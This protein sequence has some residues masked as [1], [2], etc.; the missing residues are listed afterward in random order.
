MKT[1]LLGMLL[2]ATLAALLSG[3]GQHK[4]PSEALR[5]VRVAE[6]RYDASQETNRYFGSVQARYEVDQ[7]F[8]VGGKV[9]TRKVDVGQKVRRGD[10]LATLDDTDYKLAVE[11][12]QQQLD[13]A[14]TQA[15]QAESDR[16][17]LQ[18]LKVDGSVSVSDDERATSNAATTKANAEAPHVAVAGGH[19]AGQVFGTI[20]ISATG[21]GW[22]PLAR[23]PPL[24]S[25]R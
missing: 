16:Q 21:R 22:T 15:R 12:A 9:V 6:V 18:A 20:H 11:A 17:R 14:L 7:G 2:A 19:F 24:T 1:P 3:C 13:A 4:A 23:R 5:Q 25:R 8:R 10:V